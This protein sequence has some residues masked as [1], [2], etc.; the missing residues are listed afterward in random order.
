MTKLHLWSF[1]PDMVVASDGPDVLTI[2]RQTIG[3]SGLEEYEGETPTMLADD[4]A[5]TIY[6]DDDGVRVTKLARE[7][8]EEYRRGWLCS[9]EY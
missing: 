6:N 4:T 5:I 8:S 9:S 3:D 2:M 7:W 1:G